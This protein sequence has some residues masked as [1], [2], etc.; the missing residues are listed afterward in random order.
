[1]LKRIR[2]ATYKPLA[3]FD[4][5]VMEARHSKEHPHVRTFFDLMQEILLCSKAEVPLLALDRLKDL[6]LQ[7]LIQPGRS[8][9]ILEQILDNARA[10]V[11]VRI[12]RMSTD[13]CSMTEA[14]LCLQ[15]AHR[16]LKGDAECA[17]V[18]EHAQ[19]AKAVTLMLLN[20]EADV[21][22]PKEKIK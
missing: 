21:L 2:T 1:M 3:P 20:G 9:R 19:T 5:D 15:P 17:A 8:R 16:R 14:N 12:A 10:R 13:A 7:V 11:S 4:I 18:I 6:E 22:K